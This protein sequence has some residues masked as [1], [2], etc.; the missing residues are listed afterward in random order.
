MSKS[1]RCACRGLARDDERLLT[2][3]FHSAFLEQ[4]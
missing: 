3:G 4:L 1:E 2:A